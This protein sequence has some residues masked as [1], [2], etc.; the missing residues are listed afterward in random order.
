MLF[1]LT[2]LQW[3]QKEE[4]N[5]ITILRDPEFS[6]SQLLRFLLQESAVM[7]LLLVFP[8]PFQFGSL[9]V[10]SVPETF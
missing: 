10:W 9:Q 1:T 5:A 4:T 6:L 3:M 8:Q 2:S 7:K